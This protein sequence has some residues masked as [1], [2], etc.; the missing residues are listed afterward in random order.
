MIVR[1][2]L[3]TTALAALIGALVPLMAVEP[4]GATAGAMKEYAIAGRPIA[5]GIATGA[6]G[7]LWFTDFYT[8]YVE[9]I[10]TAGKTHTYAFA[11][12]PNIATEIA[13]GPDGAL[14]VTL[15]DEIHGNGRIGR[16]TTAG[17]TSTFAV[18]G[19]SYI[20]DITAGPDGALWFTDNLGKVD[21]ITTSGVVTEFSVGGEPYHIARGP[22]G[23]LWFTDH[24]SFRIGRIT[25]SGH[26]TYFSLPAKTDFP[27]AIGTGPDGALWLTVDGQNAA[28]YRAT[29][30][31]VFTRYALPQPADYA[32]SSGIVSAPDGNLWFTVL[33]YTSN[34]GFI[35]RITPSGT[36]TE[37]PTPV[38]TSAPDGITVG[39]D[40]AV[41]FAASAGYIGRVAIR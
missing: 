39:P 25:P 40:G 32:Y 37:F 5:Q 36:V 22:D 34:K 15:L 11:V 21:R 27:D 17:S 9:R 12:S 30:A 23:N 28:V 18:P 29:T 13:A 6:D 33:D 7:A 31:G 35:G 2:R 3:R 10:T 41:W 26:V 19:T 1:H 8:P 20:D 4:V 24:S 16:I 38:A 14:W